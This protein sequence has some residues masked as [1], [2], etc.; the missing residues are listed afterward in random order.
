MI[1]IILPLFNERENIL[2]YNELLF[3]KIDEIAKEYGEPVEYIM[4]DD[5]SHDDTAE[6]LHELSKSRD[7]IQVYIHAVN[8]GMGAAIKTG[9]KESHGNCIITM[10]SDLTYRPEEVAK[11][12]DC[13]KET[14]ADCVYG[15]P[16]GKGGN[17]EGVSNIRLIPSLG[18]TFLYQIALGKRVS[19]V[20]AVIRLYRAEAI[21][22][23]T[24]DSNGFDICAEILAKMIF[25]KMNVKEVPMTL[26]SRSYGE[27]KLN[28]R[29]EIVANLRLLKKL[30]IIRMAMH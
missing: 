14:G 2:R 1:S 15:S 27:S 5:G 18:V 30:V 10:D 23:L 9:I 28:M 24:I 3:P 29:K 19:C 6:L 12:L 26:H 13:Y 11:L 7:D 22:K 20:S 4:V 21:K 8:Q 17:V 16:Y 25:S